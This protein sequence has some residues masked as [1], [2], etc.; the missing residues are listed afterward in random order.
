MPTGRP[1]C[2]NFSSSRTAG[3]RSGMKYLDTLLGSMCETWSPGFLPISTLS[4][5]KENRRSTS[6]RSAGSSGRSCGSTIS[7]G[8]P[9]SSP[10]RLPTLPE[11]RLGS[12][13]KSRA[14]WWTRAYM[15]GSL[16]MGSSW[17]SIEAMLRRWLSRQR[18][19][20]HQNAVDAGGHDG[21]SR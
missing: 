13:F 7:G 4:T 18:L 1:K 20:Q 2:S 12:G 5:L 6:R 19:K 9:W 14:G 16:R 15:T 17:G 11:P 3:T 10:P 21:G 8:S